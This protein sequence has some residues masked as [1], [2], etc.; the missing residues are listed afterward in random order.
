MFQLC[1][2]DE[3]KIKNNLPYPE[4]YH[5]TYIQ[6]SYIRMKMCT[7][8]WESLSKLGC[9]SFTKLFPEDF[10]FIFHSDLSDFSNIIFKSNAIRDIFMTLNSTISILDFK[11]Y[12]SLELIDINTL[13][14]LKSSPY[15]MLYYAVYCVL[16]DYQ[17]PNVKLL[18]D[19]LCQNSQC[20]FVW[21]YFMKYT[22][23]TDQMRTA[24]S[25]NP[26]FAFAYAYFIDM[27]E[28]PTTR[29]GVMFNQNYACLYFLNISKQCDVELLDKI[30]YP[31][32]QMQIYYTV[33]NTYKYENIDYKDFQQLALRN[34]LF[35]FDFAKKYWA[36]HGMR[37][38]VY[39]NR[40]NVLKWIHDIDGYIYDENL[41]R[42]QINIVIDLQY[43]MMLYLI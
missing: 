16:H 24:S 38:I 8:E 35:A 28:H 20:A 9:F 34:Y 22:G 31:E 21:A 12:K 3:N 37:K 5:F 43:N 13:C 41:K 2:F 4:T 17:L 42:V 6:P 32:L 23:R 40:K 36:Q 25:L 7:L 29:E 19:I 39:Q 10:E 1:K 11:F 30:K 26:C 27:E 18:H 14:A 33:R 15:M